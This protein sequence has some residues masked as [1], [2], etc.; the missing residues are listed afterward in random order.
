MNEY[1]WQQ[2]SIY[3]TCIIGGDGSILTRAEKKESQVI[4]SDLDLSTSRITKNLGIMGEVASTG[5]L[6]QALP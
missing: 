6:F 2:E 4:V 3:L 5:A 1:T